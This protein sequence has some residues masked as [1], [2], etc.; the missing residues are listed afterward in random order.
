MKKTKNQ[1][2]GNTLGVSHVCGM[3]R[4]LMRPVMRQIGKQSRLC[5]KQGKR[6]LEQLLEI[7]ESIA[8]VARQLARHAKSN[9]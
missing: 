3:N 7:E 4:S 6:I 2:K 8:I 9:K 1:P 5:L